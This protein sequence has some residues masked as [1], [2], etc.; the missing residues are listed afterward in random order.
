MSLQNAVILIG[1]AGDPNSFNGFSGELLS[2]TLDLALYQA[3]AGGPNTTKRRHGVFHSQY[4]ING[5]VK[6]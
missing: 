4:I 3:R 5:F 1:Y 2:P 6:S